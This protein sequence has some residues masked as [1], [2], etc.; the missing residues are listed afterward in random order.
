MPSAQSI[1]NKVNSVIKRV[2]PM[3]RTS[4]LRTTKITAGD[5]LTGIGIVNS[6]N[7][8]AFSPQPVYKQIGKRQA[9]YLTSASLQLVAD[10]YKFT[11]PTSQVSKSSFQAPNTYIVFKDG[12][13]TEELEIL[14]I[15]SDMFGG[16]DVAITVYARSRGHA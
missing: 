10:D 1:A 2:G 9:M 5:Q 8:V 15:D 6:Q 12:N 4:Y 11:F 14:Y 13:G 16:S 3:G 7:D